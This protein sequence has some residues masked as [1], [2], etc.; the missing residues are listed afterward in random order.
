MRHPAA[1]P[2]VSEGP[3][4]KAGWRG[5]LRP[6]GQV[7]QPGFPTCPF[8]I[9]TRDSP[10]VECHDSSLL[11]SVIPMPASCRA[12]VESRPVG[13]QSRCT[14]GTK[15]GTKK[16]TD[17]KRRSANQFPPMAQGIFP[18]RNSLPSMNTRCTFRSRS[19]TSTSA[20]LPGARLPSSLS[21]PAM[22]AGV[23]EAM[24]ITS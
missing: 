18:I 16:N 19:S 7:F 5:A 1:S 21:R 14:N 23:R 12:H 13:A 15:M 20:R 6:V 17:F 22:R 10:V 3:L 9:S 8:Y 11:A 2:H 4:R 24:R